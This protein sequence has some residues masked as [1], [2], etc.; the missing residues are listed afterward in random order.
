ML[1]VGI[2]FGVWFLLLFDMA[3]LTKAWGW[4]PNGR[5]KGFTTKKQ[6]VDLFISLSGAIIFLAGSRGL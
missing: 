1:A 5:Q 4:I 2:S 3:F 6:M